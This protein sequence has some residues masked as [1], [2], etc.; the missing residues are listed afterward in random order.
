MT[1]ALRFST[2]HAWALVAAG[3]LAACG[4]AGPR[5][6]RPLSVSVASGLSGQVTEIHLD[7]SPAGVSVVLTYDPADGQFH[8]TLSLPAG[9]ETL[10]A[11]AWA[12]TD[13]DGVLELVGSGSAVV[14]VVPE[15]GSV[16]LRIQDTGGAPPLP[17]YSP[18]IT[19]VQVSDP[20]PAI[21]QP[22]TVT[23]SATDPLGGTITYAWSADC[24]PGVDGGFADPTA[25]STTWTGA[26]AGACTLSVTAT[27]RDRCDA[28]GVTVTVAAPAPADP[29]VAVSA[30]FVPAAYVSHVTVFTAGEL[31][32]C[33]IDRDPSSDGTCRLPGFLG[34]A[35][36]LQAA[37]DGITP[38][39]SVTATDSCGGA[40]APATVSGPSA[41]FGWVA[42]SSATVCIVTFAVDRD[43]MHDELP[44]ALYAY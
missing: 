10:T 9:A 1:A 4:G 22:V 7:A 30:Q 29:A 24:D 17:G 32:E 41:W 11:T 36:L 2:L 12:D 44:V 34:G 3:L 33:E 21:G 16:Y 5:T 14:D 8:G 6:P 31:D 20:A 38:G 42:P 23:A 25:A 27:A 35:F 37:T 43:G 13:G 18:V 39:A 19:S 28:L 26:A 40:L 15:G